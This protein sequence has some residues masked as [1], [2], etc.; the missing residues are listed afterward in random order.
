MPIEP[1]PIMTM[2]PSKRACS[3]QVSVIWVTAFVLRMPFRE[4]DGSRRVRRQRDRV[5]NARPQHGQV[6]LRLGPPG[7][8]H[9]AASSIQGA[10]LELEAKQPVALVGTGHPQ[11]AGR[12]G[13][14]AE[15]PVV[16]GVAD[17]STIA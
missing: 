13:G 15:A 12:L 5:D 7:G 10:G 6:G 16:G 3:G 17:D 11:F 9:Q 8:V 2:G 4:I 14:E 1:K